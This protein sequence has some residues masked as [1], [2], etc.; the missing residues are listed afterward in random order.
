MEKV[1]S[2]VEKIIQRS[3]LARLLPGRAKLLT[4]REDPD[5]ER[6]QPERRRDPALA[7]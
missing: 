7:D 6:R 1:S 5:A 2:S 3:D 4:P